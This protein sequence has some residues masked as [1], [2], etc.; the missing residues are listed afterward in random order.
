MK[1]ANSSVLKIHLSLNH[2][3]DD[4]MKSLGEYIQAN[5]FIEQVSIGYNSITATG[6]DILRPFL[7]GNNTFKCLSLGSCY[8]LKSE[9]ASTLSK[10]IESSRIESL[11]FNVIPLASNNLIAV[12]LVQNVLKCGSSK[13]NLRS[14]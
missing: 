1:E 9:T 10:I 12:S 8:G 5:K 7:Y 3:F 6:I 2:L 14:M 13:M 4:C 11:D